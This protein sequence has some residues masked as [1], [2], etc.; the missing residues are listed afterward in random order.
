[1]MDSHGNPG[2][3]G[4]VIGVEMALEVL[5]VGVLMTVMVDVDMDVLTTVVVN[6]LVV[7]TDC[8]EAIGDSVEAADVLTSEDEGVEVLEVDV[9]EAVCI[10]VFWNEP[11]GSR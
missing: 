7:V 11:G 4:T 6:E 3:A 5:V 1:M 2:T 8:V 10:T 9:S